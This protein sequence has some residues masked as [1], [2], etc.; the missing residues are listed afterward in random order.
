MV[1]PF[2]A[3]FKRKFK[4]DVSDDK[5]AAS[6]LS[7]S[8]LSSS[9]LSSSTLSSSTL[10]SSTLSSSTL[11]SSTLSSSTL[12][13]STLSSSTLSSSTLSSSTLSS[14]TLSSST[15]SSSTLSS[16][17]IDSLHEGADLYT[18]I[19]RAGFEELNADLFPWHPGVRGEGPEGRQDGQGP[20]IQDIVL[21]G[22]STCIPKI[23]KLLQD[24]VNGRDLNKSINPDE[25]VDVT[26]LSLGIETAGGVMTVLIKRNTT[27]P[28]KQT[29]TFTAYSDNQPGVLIQLRLPYRPREKHP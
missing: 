4:E 6:T 24:L 2:M 25:E 29:Q 9:T 13:S 1:D 19:T 8:T 23:Q 11:S 16:S 18:S 12:S 22:G 17:E 10:S 5:L 7:S 14:S 15:L 27:I 28:T 3:E 26:P 21:V 20:Q